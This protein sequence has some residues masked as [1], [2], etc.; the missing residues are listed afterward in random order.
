MITNF[1]IIKSIF[2]KNFFTIITLHLLL[3]NNNSFAQLNLSKLQLIDSSK[4]NLWLKDSFFRGANVY[5]FKKFSPF[6]FDEPINSKDLIELKKLGA[7]LV[8]ANYPGVY[9]YFPPY[10]LDSLSLIVLDEIVKLTK[11][12]KLHLVISLRSGPGRSLYV[13]H[14][15]SRDDEILF[16]DTLAQKTY[17]EM[18][19]FIVER[20]KDQKHLV[21]INFLLEPHGDDPVNLLPI[22]D[23]SYF[24]FLEKLIEEVR[25]IDFKLPIIVQPQSWA[26]PSKF[27]SM[28][29]FS[30][31]L[32]VYS[33]DMYFPHQFSNELND[34]SYPGFYF[35]NDSVA[36][37]DSIYLQNF[38]IPVK[39]FKKK[40]SVPIFVNEYGGIKT[41]NGFLQYLNDLHDIFIENGFHFA[42]Y[43]W[44][45]GWLEL[46]GSSYENYN[47]E[48]LGESSKN[49]NDRENLIL[50]EIK[51]SFQFNR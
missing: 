8:V 36:Y 29:K 25:N 16:H 5:P 46:D 17:I 51:R 26:Y 12:N 30:D 21:G 11:Q 38:L 10:R 27:N 7:N 32:I 43:V 4:Y 42:F 50:K 33:F 44:R 20:Y 22:S 45:S 2:I 35:V 23:S 34:S 49:L 31:P 41:K 40:Y 14:S 3:L 18:C 13:F 6:T 39:E 48:I 28:K 9:D 37:V 47:Y 19:K 1:F 15:N 24:H